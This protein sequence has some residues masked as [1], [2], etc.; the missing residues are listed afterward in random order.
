MD[1]TRYQFSRKEILYYGLLYLCLDGAVSYLF[2]N[3]MIAFFILLPGT[4]LYFR[5]RRGS[6]QEK[7]AIR[8]QSE[9][10][11]GIQLISASLQAG[12][13][14]ENALKEAAKEL[15]KIYDKNAFAVQE[16]TYM[17]RQTAL[18][19][20]IESLLLDLGKRSGLEDIQNF[21]E[22]FMTA[23]R[24]GGDLMAIIQN[25]VSC[26][27]QKQETRMEINTCLSGKRMEQSMM[28]LIPLF[29]L[30]YVGVTSQGFLDVMYH[31]LPGVTVM[32]ICF[33]IYVTAYFWGK[34][35]MHIVI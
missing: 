13:A 29:I 34:R 3:S 31:N 11:T 33:G 25:T 16:F 22:V 28:S 19:R 1:Y 9:F 2:F 23:K 5:D 6:Q 20:S 7:R 24:T 17:V 30:G 4:V 10:L 27:Q 18:N 32:T 12:Y 15:V 26:I 35:I 21:A 8:M 14:V